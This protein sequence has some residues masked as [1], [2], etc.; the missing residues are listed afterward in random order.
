MNAPAW[1]RHV[2]KA[3]WALLCLFVFSIP[4]EKS[5]WVPGVGT[6]AR[7]LGIAAFLFIALAAAGRRSLRPPNLALVLAA[8][9]VLWVAATRFWSLDPAATG[10][11]AWTFVQLLA[12]AWMIWETCRTHARQNALTSAYVWGTAPASLYTLFRYWRGEQ[13]YYRRY[14][15]A[16]FDPNDLGLTLALAIPMALYL[17]LR[18]RGLRRWSGYAAAA[19]AICAILLTASRSALVASLIG[20]AYAAFAWRRSGLAP[21]VASAL[22]LGLLALGAVRL[23]PAHSRQRLAT[24]PAE[25]AEGTLHKRTRIWKAGLKAF[26]GH[27]LTGAGSGAYPQAVRPWL[28]TPPLKGHEYVAH[29][30]FLS[31]L[32]ECGVIGFGLFALLAATL[33][34]FVWMFRAPERALW[35]VM[36]AVW[37]AGVSTLTWEHRKPSWLLFAL[38]TTCWALSFRPQEARA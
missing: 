20:F 9:F 35:L 23:A 12:M 28:G 19:V 21:R 22:L 11:R 14:A 31:V 25:L 26:R 8:A 32:V 18:S 33:V 30:T 27:P 3:G 7:L 37:T 1:A 38:I 6:I 17:G 16:G 13:T 36:L 10:A 4:W 2:E 15:A 5:V 34:V 24:L 29:N